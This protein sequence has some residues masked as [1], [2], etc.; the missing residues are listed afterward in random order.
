MII[1]RVEMDTEATGLLK[2]MLRIKLPAEKAIEKKLQIL[3]KDPRNDAAE[4]KGIPTKLASGAEVRMIWSGDLSTARARNGLN[5]VAAVSAEL[6]NK[7]SEEMKKLKSELE[8]QIKVNADTLLEHDTKITAYTAR[9]QELMDKQVTVIADMQKQM[10]DSEAA[11]VKSLTDTEAA[12]AKALADTEA[13]FQKQMDDMRSVMREQQQMQLGFAADAA[14]LTQ[15]LS[16][17]MVGVKQEMLEQRAAV[18]ASALAIKE[19]KDGSA[20]YVDVT[21]ALARRQCA[22]LRDALTMHAR[23]T[24][25]ATLART[26]LLTTASDPLDGEVQLRSVEYQRGDGDHGTGEEDNSSGSSGAGTAGNG[27]IALDA[28]TSRPCEGR[29]TGGEIGERGAAHDREREA[30]PFAG[31]TGGTSGADTDRMNASSVNTRGP[32]TLQAAGKGK[33]GS[34]PRRLEHGPS[35]RYEVNALCGALGGILCVESM[36]TPLSMVKFRET[37]GVL[38]STRRNG[39]AKFAASSRR[40]FTSVIHA[41]W[42]VFA[43]LLPASRC[44]ASGA[45]ARCCTTLDIRYEDTLGMQCY[46]TAELRCYGTRQGPWLRHEGIKAQLSPRCADVEP[47][48]WSCTQSLGAVLDP[49]HLCAVSNG[50][51]S[52]RLR[53][54][55]AAC[56]AT[57]R[58]DCTATA[59]ACTTP[60]AESSSSNAPPSR[61]RLQ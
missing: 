30:Q 51:S 35:E 6:N 13:S 32:V 20:G 55:A 36:S 27:V 29:V 24:A 9:M 50:R 48:F 11:H 25:L 34:M 1:P 46:D 56:S 14:Q 23:V 47:S 61:T 45:I 18:Q 22:V 15:A 54:S 52:K 2:L 41:A 31:E 3:C 40:S 8:K 58:S 16:S 19:L 53:A 5:R 17:F 10:G 28:P 37:M 60:R 21:S 4:F 49:R 57:L 44:D 26:G 7:S 39:R 43:L 38:S 59:V 42:T 12:H 33:D